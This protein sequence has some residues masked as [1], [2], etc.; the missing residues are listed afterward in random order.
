MTE[1]TPSPK[2]ETAPGSEP[3]AFPTDLGFGTEYEKWL[4]T[5]IIE[6]LHRTYGFRSAAD[7]PCNLLLGDSREVFRSAGVPCTRLRAP[8]RDT[9]FDLLFSFCEF[10]QAPDAEA[11]LRTLDAFES[12]YV[13]VVTQNWRNPGVPLHRLYHLLAGVPW[14]HGRLSRASD[15]AVL[16]TV[17]RCGLRWN[18]VER[19]CFDTPWFV[20]DVYETGTFLRKLVPEGARDA[21]ST[22]MTR[23]RFEGLPLAVSRYLAHHF[24]LLFERQA[25]EGA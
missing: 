25:G 5:G 13:M 20:L 9:R 3:V 4:L 8:E 12:R 7:Y 1:G 18:L 19:R 24:L 15:A 16:R 22:G 10:E 17:R 14:D 11:F 2:A 21:P 6:E 23:S